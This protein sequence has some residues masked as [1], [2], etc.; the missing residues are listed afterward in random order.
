[1]RSITTL[2]PAI[3]LGALLLSAPAFAQFPTVPA[4]TAPDGA[5]PDAASP[6]GA[7]N[8]GV[9]V[10]AWDSVRGVSLVQYVG[11]KYNDIVPANMEPASGG[12][13]DFHVLDKWSSTFG[14]SDAANIQYNV[15]SASLLSGAIGGRRL[16]TTGAL[17]GVPTVN[18]LATSGAA[19]TVQQFI[20]VNVTGGCG[21]VNS[22]VATDSTQA[23]YAGNDVT[24]GAKLNGQLPFVTTAAVGTALGFFSLTP[25]SNVPPNA[26]TVHQYGN[27]NGFASWLLDASG[28]LTYTIPGG[29]SVPLPAAVWL[30]LSGLAGF[31]TVSR[32]KLR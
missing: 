18:N 1:M 19:S 17:S 12:V 22:C 3:A 20:N 10:S 32:R 13:L 14:G 21:T 23:Q 9:I 6:A 27:A 11:L 16:D 24:F 25:T 26:A 5:W 31:G 29:G 8:G 2:S 28:D 30:L 15:T 7:G 4:D